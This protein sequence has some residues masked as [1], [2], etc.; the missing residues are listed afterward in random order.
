MRLILACFA[1]AAVHADVIDTKGFH[2]EET[3]EPVEQD[4]DFSPTQKKM[5]SRSS[6]IRASIAKLA[7]TKQT[8]LEKC[9]DI[10]RGLCP[11][12]K[13]GTGQQCLNCGR[14]IKFQLMQ[15]NCFVSQVYE[16][17]ESQYTDENVGHRKYKNA[18][19]RLSH[20]D[21]LVHD[22][23]RD[24]AGWVETQDKNNP[25]Q[26][27]NGCFHCVAEH[28]KELEDA[29]QKK[30]AAKKMCTHITPIKREHAAKG[31]T[32]EGACVNHVIV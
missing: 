13:V 10:F 18:A 20:C 4:D 32:I 11:T 25:I 28:W 15:S 30:P 9:R 8:T 14:T 2:H 31:S 1:L 23:C 22:Y 12:A 6:K 3:E 7:Y 16:I 26:R 27:S 19:D 21:L 29:C 24:V 5:S 17:C